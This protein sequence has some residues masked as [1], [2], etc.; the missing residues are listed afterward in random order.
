LTLTLDLDGEVSVANLV[1]TAHGI[2]Q[3]MKCVRERV[4]RHFR[5]VWIRERGEK[6]GRLHLHI[7]WTAGYVPQDWLSATAVKC[8][9]GKILDVRSALAKGFRNSTLVERYVTKTCVAQY[10]SKVEGAEHP[11]RGFPSGTRIVQTSGV[12][13]YESERGWVYQ[14]L[15][16]DFDPEPPILL[17]HWSITAKLDS[18]SRPRVLEYSW[19]EPYD[20]AVARQGAVK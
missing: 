5:F 6:T 7:L 12:P 19:A 3:F 20:E 2:N 1:R 11:D 10:V 18:H 15:T 13:A 16:P 14:E 8:G 9:F 17:L 4:H